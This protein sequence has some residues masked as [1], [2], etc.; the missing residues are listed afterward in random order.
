MHGSA[1]GQDVDHRHVGEGEDHTEEHGDAH[2]RQKHGD[3]DLEEP[4]PETGP[5]DLGG[6]ED[7]L[8]DGCQAAQ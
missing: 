3:H 7:V 6:I 8:G 5:I 1:S 4:A 2:D